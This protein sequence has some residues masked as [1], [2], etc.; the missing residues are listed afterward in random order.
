MAEIKINLYQ[1]DRKKKAWNSSRYKAHNIICETWW[2]MEWACMAS[3]GTGLLVFS[4]NVTED[5]SSRINSEVYWDIYT[6]CPD[7]AKWSKVDWMALHITSG[8]WPK[9]LKKKTQEILKVKGGI[10]CNGQVNFLILTQ[11]SM[12]FTCSR[13]NL[14]QKDPQKTTTEASCSKDL[15]K[16]HKMWCPWVPGL[17]QSLATKDSPLNI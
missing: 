15:A 17:S 14:R 8:Q 6:L 16:H 4:D 3:S 1:N 11:L 7:S 10:F 12:H 2:M 5:R 13:Q 9:T